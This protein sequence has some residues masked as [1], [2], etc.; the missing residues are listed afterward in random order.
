MS[1][2]MCV[3]LFQYRRTLSS[4]DVIPIFTNA[5]NL[6]KDQLSKVLMDFHLLGID[7]QGFVLAYMRY[8]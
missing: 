6:L 2:F 4:V 7:T 1:V 5:K 8:G 3:L